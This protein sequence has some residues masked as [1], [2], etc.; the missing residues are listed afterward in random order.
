MASA[1]EVIAALQQARQKLTEA[2][3]RGLQ[4]ASIFGKAHSTVGHVLGRAGAGSPL[5]AEM[6]LKEKALVEEVM[7][8]DGLVTRVDAAIAQARSA[9]TS[10]STR[11]GTALPRP[12]RAV[13]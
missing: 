8:L 11:G 3:S 9:S 10:G 12:E 13:P 5:L 7:R 4:A 6:R 1:D 2:K